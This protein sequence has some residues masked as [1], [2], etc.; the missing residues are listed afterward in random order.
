MSNINM[1]KFLKELFARVCPEA[2]PE[3]YEEFCRCVA[4]ALGL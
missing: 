2:S 1:Y 4:K 3:Q